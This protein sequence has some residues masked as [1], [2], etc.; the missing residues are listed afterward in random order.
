MQW[1]EDTMEVPD[2]KRS[3]STTMKFDWFV[4]RQTPSLSNSPTMLTTSPRLT[5]VSYL[6]ETVTHSNV[7]DACSSHPL[8]TESLSLLP[9]LLFYE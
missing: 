4:I 8:Y 1:T 3:G 2:S 7:N 6:A 5:A 9:L